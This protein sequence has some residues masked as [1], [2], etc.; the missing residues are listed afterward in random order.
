MAVNNENNC[1]ASPVATNEQGFILVMA[2][3]MLVVLSLMGTAA[4]TVRN[5]EVSIATNAEII[6]HNFYALEAVTLE[7]TAVLEETDDNTLRNLDTAPLAWLK[8][9]DPDVLPPIDPI[10]LSKRATWSS[11]QIT[12]QDTSINKTKFPEPADPENPNRFSIEPPGYSNP[13]DHIQYA[14]VQGNL[15]SDANQ[16]DLCAGSDQSDP[17]KQEK[18]YSVFGMY[19]VRSGSGKAYSGR[20]MLMVGY[21]KTVYNNP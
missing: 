4:M 12:P 1:Q 17:T 2:L 14:A 7:G 16:Y 9:N 3:L 5:T 21:K 19:D 11:P 6:Q 8:P 13:P 20:R 15:H 10:D 18:C